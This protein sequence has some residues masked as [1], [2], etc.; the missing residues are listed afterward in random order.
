M[1]PARR[2]LSF[3]AQRE[4]IKQRNLLKRQRAE[5]ASSPAQAEFCT[6]LGIDLKYVIPKEI[7]FQNIIS[8]LNVA[9]QTIMH[10]HGLILFGE[11]SNL[12]TAVNRIKAVFQALAG[13]DSDVVFIVFGPEDGFNWAVPLLDKNWN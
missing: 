3:T 2:P 13:P 4:Q 7:N 10:G 5:Q 11:A 8:N 12:K 9:L 1:P 6:L